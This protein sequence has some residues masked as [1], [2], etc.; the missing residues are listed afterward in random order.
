M[1]LELEI[2]E[3]ERIREENDGL[4]TVAA[5]VEAAKDEDSP[6]HRHFDW[7]DGSA[8][9]KYREWQARTLIQKCKITIEHRPDTIVRAYVSVP[10][11]RK[12][13]GYRT[14]QDVIDNEDLKASL[15]AEMGRRI[16][17]WQKQYYLLD[18][19]MLKALKNLEAILRKRHDAEMRDLG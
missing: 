18:S 12:E 11:D 3:L 2:D 19:E 6:L 9:E 17:Y 4:L 10:S 13:G 14:V 5:I 7:N 15:L 1:T 8:A 16:A